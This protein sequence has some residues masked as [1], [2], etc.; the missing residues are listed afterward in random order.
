MSP[1]S[2]PITTASAQ[3]PADPRAPV[4]L[5]FQLHALRAALVDRDRLSQLSKDWEK[6][7]VY[8][9][10]G[11]LDS[12]TT[13]IYVGKAHGKKGVRSR[14]FIQRSK[15]RLATWWRAL[16]VLRGTTDGFNSAEVGYLEGRLASELGALPNLKVIEG[17]KDID[18]TLPEHTLAELDALVPTILSA[19]RVAGLDLQEDAETTKE[20]KL[21]S[22]QRIEGSV[23]ELLSAGLLAAGTKLIFSRKGKSARATITSSGGMVVDGIEYQTPSSAA[24]AAHGVKTVNGWTAWK[25]DDSN[26]KSLADLRDQLKSTSQS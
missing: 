20:K 16:A 18:L 10:M 11:R 13:E 21:Q 12:G 9:L 19:L 7:G 8:I 26:G 23:A 1:Q 22:S 2:P 24:K 17:K 14:L 15:P 3:I 5:Y 4:L 25:L 6:P